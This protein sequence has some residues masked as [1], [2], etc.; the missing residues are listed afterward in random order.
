LE[1]F[2]EKLIKRRPDRRLASCGFLPS[3]PGWWKELWG[4]WFGG[5]LWDG[6]A[7]I[8]ANS[9]ENL[10]AFEWIASYPK[11]FGAED[12]LA[13]HEGF[14]N[15]ASAQNPFFTGRVAMVLQGP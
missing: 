1:Q 4:I 8:T 12:L 15:F 9:P 3:E 13:F 11:R 7:R 5:S 14:G 2:N 6:H 10:T